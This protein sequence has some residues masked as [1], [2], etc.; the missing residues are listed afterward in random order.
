V[1]RAV[2]AT[3]GAVVVA[4]A[5]LGCPSRSG[6]A[7]D[8]AVSSDADARA[9]AEHLITDLKAGQ[10]DVAVGRFCDQRPVARWLAEGLLRPALSQPTLH[11]RRVEPAW[12]GATPYFYVELGVHADGS[13]DDDNVDGGID[14]DGYV[15]GFGVDVRVGCLERAVGEAALAEAL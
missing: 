8:L 5:G 12:V 6:D 4:G 10:L 14:D 15:H 7:N 9:V 1:I 3:I 11:L 13:A 2:V